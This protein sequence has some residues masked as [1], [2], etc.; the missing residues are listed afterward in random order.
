MWDDPYGRRYITGNECQIAVIFAVAKNARLP[1][2]A[3]KAK[4]QIL[5]NSLQET[6]TGRS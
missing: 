6:T 4:K 5:Y 1:R 3:G 2:F